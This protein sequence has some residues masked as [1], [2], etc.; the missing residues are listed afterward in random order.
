MPGLEW[1]DLFFSFARVGELVQR[2]VNCAKG[3]RSEG[4]ALASIS[5]ALRIQK[6]D[7]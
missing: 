3:R 2:E 5:R 4:P 7:L 1:V 6:H